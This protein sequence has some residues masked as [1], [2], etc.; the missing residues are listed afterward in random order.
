[1]L[2]KL[3]THVKDPMSGFFALKRSVVDDVKLDARGYKIGLEILAKGVY[4]NVVEVPFVFVDRKAGVSKMNNRIMREYLAQLFS[5]LFARN[6]RLLRFG[7]FCIVGASGALVNLMVLY[8][9]TEFLSIWY[10]VSAALAFCAA[11]TS[12]YVLNETWTFHVA[13]SKRR[14]TIFSYTK[15][16][17]VS[18]LGLA[19]NLALLF[20]L[21][22]RFR[23]WYI[24][25]QVFAIAAVTGWNYYGSASW[26]FAG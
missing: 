13:H 26:A 2:A 21:V 18:V 4:N 25:A 14:T 11:V 20:V 5:V 10:I 15:F 17:A 19:I 3:V 9:L 22:E 6:S 12:N 1:M 23:L 7:K 16:L 24:L 8:V